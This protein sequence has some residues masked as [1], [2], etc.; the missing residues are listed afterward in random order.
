MVGSEQLNVPTM[1]GV[2][3]PSVHFATHFNNF[4]NP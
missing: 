4:L 1:E 3:P 2:L